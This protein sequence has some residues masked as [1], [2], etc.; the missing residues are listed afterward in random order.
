MLSGVGFQPM[1]NHI[2]LK[3]FHTADLERKAQQAVQL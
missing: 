2:T 1:L 3:V